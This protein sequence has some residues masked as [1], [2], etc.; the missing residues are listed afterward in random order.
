MFR[1]TILSPQWADKW[2]CCF[3]SRDIL[4]KKSREKKQAFSKNTKRFVILCLLFLF[5]FFLW[6]N[7]SYIL[8]ITIDLLHQ[9]SSLFDKDL[10]RSELDCLVFIENNKSGIKISFMNHF[11]DYFWKEKTKQ[12]QQQQSRLD[13]HKNLLLTT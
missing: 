10:W 11:W 6:K 1:R 12:Q 3:Y 9:L 5:W 7:V 13:I 4:L 8:I 2:D